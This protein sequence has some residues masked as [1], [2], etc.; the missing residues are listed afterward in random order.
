MKKSPCLS[1]A[2]NFIQIQL[3]KAKSFDQHHVS[4][5]LRSSHL[6]VF[7]RKVVLRNFLK[8]T[9]NTC[10]RVSFS[11]GLRP[12][13]LLKKRLWHRCF[14]VNFAK[15][16]RTPFLTEHLQW[17]LLKTAFWFSVSTTFSKKNINIFKDSLLVNRL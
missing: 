16:L 10:A 15:F 7:C 8:F 9:G 4:L 12:A 6:K 11:T 1:S 3:F 13:T 14:P 17:L 5:K 2:K